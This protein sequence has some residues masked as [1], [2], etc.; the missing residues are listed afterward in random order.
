MHTHDTQDRA[1]NKPSRALA[2]LSI[3]AGLVLLAI[4]YSISHAI[5]R[6][7]A[8]ATQL[9][10]VETS[11][12][13]VGQDLRI[14]PDEVVQGDAIV[15]DGDMIVDGEV[16]GN[17]VVVQGDAYINGKVIGDVSIMGGDAKLAAG[18]SVTGNVLVLAG[19][20]VERAPGASVGGEISTVD[21]PILPINASVGLPSIHGQPTLPSERLDGMFST[22][23]RVATLVLVLGIT[24]L[25]TVFAL[26]FALIVPHRLRVANATL[27]A[28]PGSSV[29]VGLIVALLLWPVFG[30]V[31]MV[32]TLTIVGIVL[33]PVLGIMVALALL[34]GLA[35][36][37]LWLGRRVYES[38]RHE[39]SPLQGPQRLMLETL[40]G[41]GVVMSATLFPTL[42][43]PGWISSLLWMLVYLAACLGL[44]AGVMSRF[45]TLVPPTRQPSTLTQS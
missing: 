19:G 35:N 34:F 15:T 30:V 37:S 8:A 39:T 11:K 32:L 22:L 21:L 5:A 36:V 44:G 2:L 41:L 16:R 31:S 29:A 9:A 18:S 40:L 43:L 28:V 42:L 20:K 13:A 6:A 1:Y 4:T 23:G 3:A 45:G 27:E 25:L 7:S 14:Q 38:V 26:A 12:N 10:Q 17:V 33:V 24:L